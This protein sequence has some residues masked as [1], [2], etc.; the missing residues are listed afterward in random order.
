MRKSY[1]L[2]LKKHYE[3]HAKSIINFYFCTRAYQN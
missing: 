3:T 1:K 2:P